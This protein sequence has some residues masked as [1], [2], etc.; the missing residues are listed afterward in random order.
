MKIIAHL[1]TLT[2]LLGTVFIKAEPPSARE[3][4]KPI[5]EEEYKALQY[6]TMPYRLL[7]PDKYDKSKQYPLVLFSTVTANG[8]RTTRSS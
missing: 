4:K 3:A 5:L 6:K 8:A 2:V 7:I 1:L